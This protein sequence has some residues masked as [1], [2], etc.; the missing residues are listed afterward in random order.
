MC[1]L[2]QSS[3]LT[4]GI[5]SNESFEA[6]TGQIMQKGMNT[7]NI[8]SMPFRAME[9]GLHLACNANETTHRICN[10]TGEGIQA[11]VN[12]VPES[13][14]TSINKIFEE[15]HQDLPQRLQAKYG[16]PTKET[17]YFLESTGYLVEALAFK[18][19]F[20]VVGSSCKKL[21]IILGKEPKVLSRKIDLSLKEQY[22]AYFQFLFQKQANNSLNVYVNFL[23]VES[24]LVLGTTTKTN[25]ITYQALRVLKAVANEQGAKNIYIQWYPANL[26]LLDTAFKAKNLQFIGK[27]PRFFIQPSSS[28]LPVFKMKVAVES[29]F[30]NFLRMTAPIALPMTALAMQSFSS[31]YGHRANKIADLLENF[32]RVQYSFSAEIWS[33]SETVRMFAP[34][35][36]FSN[37]NVRLSKPGWSGWTPLHMTQYEGEYQLTDFLIKKGALPWKDKNGLYPHQVP[38][39][40][41]VGLPGYKASYNKTN[42]LLRKHVALTQSTI[43]LFW[44]TD[45]LSNP[46]VRLSTP[47]WS[48]WTPLHTTQYYAEPELTDFLKKIGAVPYKDNMG[49]Y[50]HQV[51]VCKARAGLPGYRANYGKVNKLLSQMYRVQHAKEQA[52][53]RHKLQQ[54]QQAKMQAEYNKQLAEKRY[55]AETAYKLQHEKVQAEYNNLRAEQRYQ[56]ADAYYAKHYLDDWGSRFNYWLTIAQMCDQ[57]LAFN[58]NHCKAIKLRDKM[59]LESGGVIINRSKSNGKYITFAQYKSEQT[60]GSKNSSRDSGN[61]ASISSY[62]SSRGG[63]EEK[64]NSGRGSITINSYKADGKTY[65]F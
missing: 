22:E 14:R 2:I 62:H 63:S 31:T 60:N 30:Q 20:S 10:L 3:T 13:I 45:I 34:I 37:P 35:D 27:K 57:A 53:A 5:H 32:N 56:A 24:D 43:D 21:P 61:G 48:G 42:E 19:A 33:F 54:A 23:G 16:I 15:I 4:N 50:P 29:S 49:L 58:P 55:Q 28:E 47:G 18:G 11:M 1:L 7:I 52:E 65:N 36:I 25:G 38:C 17:T 40:T 46:N 64:P 59:Y 51:P 26:K 44:P 6:V 41:K 9:K 8:L 39:K 12:I